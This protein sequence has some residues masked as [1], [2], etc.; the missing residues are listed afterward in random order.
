MNFFLRRYASTSSRLQVFQNAVQI[1]DPL[2]I[3]N[4]GIIAHI[5]AGRD[6][7]EDR[8]Q[9]IHIENLFLIQEK[10]PQSNECFSMRVSFGRWVML[11]MEIRRWITWIKNENEA[12]PLRQQQLQFHGKNNASI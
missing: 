3:R 1:S 4:I 6:Q 12:S 9:T 10:Q 8:C 2:R 7:S 11:M 5:D